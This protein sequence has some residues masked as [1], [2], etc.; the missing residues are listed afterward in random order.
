MADIWLFLHEHLPKKTRNPHE[1]VFVMLFLTS[2]KRGVHI[3]WTYAWK[4]KN[5]ELPLIKS[6]I[7]VRH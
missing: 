4:K 3:R 1:H 7:V 6:N 5:F 2:M